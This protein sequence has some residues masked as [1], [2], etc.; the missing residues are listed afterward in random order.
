MASA[1]LVNSNAF[2]TRVFVFLEE[3]V[4]NNNSVTRTHNTH[5]IYNNRQK[6]IES[7]EKVAQ[8]NEYIT[9]QEPTKS[10][11]KRNS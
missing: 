7:A 9:Y 3:L 5:E 2:K 8:K 10:S 4:S 1:S 11:K 6:S